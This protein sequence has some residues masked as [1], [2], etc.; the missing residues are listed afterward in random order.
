VTGHPDTLAGVLERLPQA[1]RDRLSRSGLTKSRLGPLLD[2]P[3]DGLLFAGSFADE[4]STRDSDLDFVVLRTVRQP[5]A[6]IC[7]D[8]GIPQRDT[9]TSPMIDRL[10]TIQS[11]VEFDLWLVAEDQV[12]GLKQAMAAAVSDDG[13]LTT[14]PTLSPLEAKLLGRLHTGQVLSGQETVARWRRDLRVAQLPDCL[15]ATAIADAL[16]L[17][18]DALNLAR[19]PADGGLGSPLAGLLTARSAAERLLMAALTGAGIVCSDLRFAAVQRERMLAAGRAVPAA[20]ADLEQLAFPPRAAHADGQ[21]E[22]D[23]YLGELHR[24]ARIL[25]G[26]L[27]EGPRSSVAAFLRDFGRGRWQLLTDVLA[28]AVT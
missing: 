24:H 12:S 4:L 27:D 8:R 25:V 23:L 13:Q 15:T 5:V 28:P 16:S 6:R 21:A 14:L 22:L 2:W 18:E 10:L 11:G 19:E 7:R 9:G 17:L 3:G 1:V 20:L 26:E